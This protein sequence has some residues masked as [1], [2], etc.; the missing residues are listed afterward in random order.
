MSG[1]VNVPDVHYLGRVT[2]RLFPLFAVLGLLLAPFGRRS[3]AEAMNA[4]SGLA[5]QSTMSGHCADMPA[6]DR[7]KS[8]KAK[9]DCMTACSAVAIASLTMI[10]SVEPQ[11]IVPSPRPDLVFTGISLEAEPPP[12]RLS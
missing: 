6:P 8:N 10:E 12:P 1:L 4:H 2:L 5:H 11:V 7:S 3:S 9:L